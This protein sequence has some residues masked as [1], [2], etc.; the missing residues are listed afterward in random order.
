MNAIATLALLWALLLG[1]VA[2][3]RPTLFLIGDSTMADK[4]DPERNPERGWGQLLPRFLDDRVTVRNF[5]VNGRSSKSF[6]DE[7]KW[8][9]VLAQLRSGDYVLIQFGHNDYKPTD[10]K[11][12]TN[13]YTAYRRNM[14]RYVAEARAKGATPV[15]LSS[16][17]QRKFNASGVLEDTHGAYP[18]VAREVARETRTPFVD[19]QLL[20][21]ELVMRAGPDSAKALYLWVAPGASAMYPEGKQDDTHLSVAGATQIARL[22]AAGLKRSGLPLARH[23][24]GTE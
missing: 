24:V 21:E 17:V 8:D 5:A 3:P 19:L 7:G 4:P 23:V 2:Q 6:I 9:A 1:A 11:R 14:E 13:P 18:F 16:I 22:A 10:P 15:I 20:T 12:H